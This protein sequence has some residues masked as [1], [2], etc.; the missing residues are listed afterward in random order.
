M[1]K[2]IIII[3]GLIAAGAY[4]AYDMM[5]VPTSYQAAQVTPIESSAAKEIVPNPS[6]TALDG[7]AYNLHDLKGKIVILNFWATWCAPCKVEFPDLLKIADERKDDIVFVALSVDNQP[8]VI[9]PFLKR[10]PAGVQNIIAAQNVI[11]AHDPNKSISLDMFQS[12]KYRETYVI[13]PDL[14]IQRKIVGA[15]TPDDIQALLNL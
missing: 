7:T 8:D 15:L 3:L 1:K 13:A 4:M 14:S 9:A 2:I 10:L 12:I 11:I 6:F 5:R